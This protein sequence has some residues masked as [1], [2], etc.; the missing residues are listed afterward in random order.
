VGPGRHSVEVTR[1]TGDGTAAISVTAPDRPL[2]LAIAHDGAD[3]ATRVDDGAS[4]VTED[5]APSGRVLRRRVTDATTGEML[6]DT[7]FG[8]ADAGDAPAWS[9]PAAGGPT[10]TYVA[11]PAGLLAVTTAAG[12]SWPASDA[13]Q[14]LVG[15]TGATGAHTPSPATDE[16]GR[17][18]GPAPGRLGP[19]GTQLRFVTDARTGI[20]RMGVRLYDPGAGRSST[21]RWGGPSW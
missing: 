16:W 15:T 2:R 3:H 20:V 5:L 19:W 8:Y 10:T 13:R 11:G 12:A 4:V 18:Q 7:V 14:D 6:E 1:S 9:R 17:T 21:T